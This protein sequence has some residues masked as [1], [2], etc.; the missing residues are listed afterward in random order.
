MNH[1]V[2][3]YAVCNGRVSGWCLWVLPYWTR[4]YLPPLMKAV[5]QKGALYIKSQIVRDSVVFK[6]W[7][8]YVTKKKK[9]K[10]K[11]SNRSEE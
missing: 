5:Y 4:Q 1:T 7:A 10:K 6:K 3:P 11:K 8:R 2:L 9:K